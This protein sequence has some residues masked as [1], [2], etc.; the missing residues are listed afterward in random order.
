MEAGDGNKSIDQ[1]MMFGGTSSRRS[2]VLHAARGPEISSVELQGLAYHPFAP[3]PP[4]PTVAPLIFSSENGDTGIA[5]ISLLSTCPR[6]LLFHR[7]HM[8]TSSGL[9]STARICLTMI[10]PNLN[11]TYSIN[12]QDSEYTREAT[13]LVWSFEGTHLEP[14][15]FQDRQSQDSPPCRRMG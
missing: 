8:I 4:L 2:L 1:V 14:G 15:H 3:I 5:V 12:Q 13:G 9:Q 7:S 10:I 11:G 6:A